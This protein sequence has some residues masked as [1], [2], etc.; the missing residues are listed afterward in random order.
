M[1]TSTNDIFSE[2]E[3][4][5]RRMERTWRQVLGPP[6]SPRFSPPVLEPPA[7]IYETAESV[8]VVV[9]IAGIK[10]QDV[11]ISVDGNTLTIRGQREEPSR[12]AVLGV[13]AGK[14]PD[15]KAKTAARPTAVEAPTERQTGAKETDS[16]EVK[17]RQPMPRPQR[18]P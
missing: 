18:K 3:G 4:I 5:R 12:L 1:M 17:S 9:E 11:E 2:F 7:D 8:V 6:G 15:A 14:K 10:D 13:A 16:S